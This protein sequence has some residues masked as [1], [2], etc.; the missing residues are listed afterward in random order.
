LKVVRA[1]KTKNHITATTM[2]A[3]MS[4]EKRGRPVIYQSRL[5]TTEPESVSGTC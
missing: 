3:K 1:G 5:Y 2:P 4:M